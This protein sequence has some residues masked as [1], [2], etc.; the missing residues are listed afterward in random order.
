MAR[1]RPRPQ[2]PGAPARRPCT[3][4]R[5][6]GRGARARRGCGR[7]R[8]RANYAPRLETSRGLR[9]G[10]PRAM[11]PLMSL[12]SIAEQRFIEVFNLA[13]KHLEDRYELPVV[14]SDVP[15]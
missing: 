9:A 6:D 12:E 3:A 11:I 7:G 13:E 4:V 14:I 2:P 15:N 1:G 5:P 8:P 10:R